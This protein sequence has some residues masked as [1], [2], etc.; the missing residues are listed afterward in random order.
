VAKFGLIFEVTEDL[1]AMREMVELPPI[2]KVN[3]DHILK[4]L[5]EAGFLKIPGVATGDSS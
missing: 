1:E 3:K 5:K 2:P 4:I